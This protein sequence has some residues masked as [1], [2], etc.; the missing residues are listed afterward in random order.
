MAKVDMHYFREAL[1]CAIRKGFDGDEI[2]STLDIKI[3][4]KPK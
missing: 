1:N 3:T 4:P 2:L